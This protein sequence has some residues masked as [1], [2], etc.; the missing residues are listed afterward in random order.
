MQTGW[1]PHDS[2]ARKTLM[3]REFFLAKRRRACFAWFGLF[4]FVGHQAFKAWLKAALNSWYERFYDTLQSSGTEFASGENASEWSTQ[5]REAIMKHLMD[6]AIIVAPAIVVHPVAG[7]IR[8]CWVLEWR[9]SV[10]KAYISAWDITSSP[11]EGAAQRVHEDTQR[12][13]VGIQS[14][15]SVILEALL[16][17]VIFCPVLYDLAPLLM[18]VAVSVALGGLMMSVVLGYKL[19]SLEV[20][21][22]IVEAAVRKK[23]VVLEVDPTSITVEQSPISSFL[24]PITDLRR[25]YRRLYCNFA[26][27]A[28]WLALYEQCAVLVPYAFS[29]AMLFAMDPNKRITLGVLIKISNAFGKVFDSVNIVSDN[30]L[31]VNEWRSV[32]VRLR[33]FERTIYDE[34][35]R[36]RLGIHPVPPAQ[37]GV[38]LRQG[39]ESPLPRRRNAAPP[40]TGDHLEI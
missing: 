24:T 6:F 21:N 18:C 31:A 35:A 30:W 14:C 19:V 11:I 40:W 2:S 23:L 4:V 22:Q 16:T 10:M 39:A 33:E 13:A 36:A 20:N 32:L 3:F 28:T 26:V 9:I 29:G 25:N 27:L 38:E 5:G 1:N 37:T 12:F 34:Q 7:L 15:V 17:L 8:N